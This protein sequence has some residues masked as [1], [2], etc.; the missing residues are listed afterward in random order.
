MIA[1][2]EIKVEEINGAE[3]LRCGDIIIALLGPSGSGRSSFVDAAA[4]RTS[5]KDDTLKCDSTASEINAIRIVNYSKERNS[6]VLVDTPGTD[7]VAGDLGVLLRINTWIR[8]SDSA[9]NYIGIFS[10]FLLLTSSPRAPMP[11]KLAGIIYLHRI[12]DSRITTACP[13]RYISS[14][15]ESMGAS[16]VESA[17]KHVILATTMWNNDDAVISDSALWESRELDLAMNYWNPF[18]VRGSSIRRFDKS[19]KSAR[20]IIESCLCEGEDSDARNIQTALGDLRAVV[21]ESLYQTLDK[22]LSEQLS[23]VHLLADEAELHDS[24]RANRLR[25]QYARTQKEL[26]KGV[27][28]MRRRK[29]PIRRR[30]LLRFFP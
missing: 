5:D 20:S 4:H 14:I 25:V 29:T 1:V 8:R 28:E 6:L 23:I 13:Y 17:C 19:P 7:A 10:A 18:L 16:S 9:E 11:K 30:I 21:N 27:K 12:S 15:A 3:E 26:M 24:E 22:L 2:E